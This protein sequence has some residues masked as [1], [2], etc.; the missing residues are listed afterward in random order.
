MKYLSA[1]CFLVVLITNFRGYANQFEIGNGDVSALK[2]AIIASNSNN[3]PDTIHLAFQG[4]YSFTVSDNDFVNGGANALPV[5]TKDGSDANYLTIFANGATLARSGTIDVLRLLYLLDCKV[6]IHDMNLIG[7]STQQFANKGGA[8]FLNS[9][10]LTIY[11]SLFKDNRAAEGG[12]IYSPSSDGSLVAKNCT[13]TG[14]TATFGTGAAIAK[15]YGPMSLEN[16]TVV[17]NRCVNVNTP[18]AI[19]NM[20]PLNA[21][22][23]T[24]NIYL[25]NTIVARNTYD[26]PGSPYNGQEFDI[27]GAVYTQGNN[28]IGA[29]PVVTQLS[30]PT[31]RQGEPNATNDYVGVQGSP[32]NPMLDQ[33]GANGYFTQSFKPLSGS[34]ALINNAGTKSTSTPL[35]TSNGIIPHEAYSGDVITVTGMNMAG[36]TKVQFTGSQSYPVTT[37]ATNAITVAVPSNAQTGK[38]LIMDNVPNFLF[39]MLAIKVKP[40]V[41]PITP[42][43]VATAKSASSIII[44]WND[45]Q[46]EESYRIEYKT[47]GQSVYRLLTIVNADAT[48]YT[49]STF[50]CNTEYHFRIIAVGHGVESSPSAI[51]I[52]TTSMDLPNAPQ[53]IVGNQSPNTGEH[54]V[55]YKT[56]AE[57]GLIYSWTYN[58]DGA[59]L[60]PNAASVS[61]DFSETATPGTLSVTSSN[62]CGN[63]SAT[64]L[65]INPGTITAMEEPAYNLIRIYPNPSN[66]QFIIDG[67][68][69]RGYYTYAIRDIT[70]QV[71]K[72]GEAKG[73]KLISLSYASA[74]VYSVIVFIN[75]EQITT[76]LIIVD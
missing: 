76:K 75:N 7:G 21:N 27:A 6:V 59:T 48:S 3:Q 68:E 43:L 35:L 49:A 63:S 62:S 23:A 4:M 12:A 47:S 37:A 32:I 44:T 69:D 73:K 54:D 56:A 20:I 55:L 46:H 52:A 30:Q 36:I 57:P 41:T 1:C 50:I 72:A 64:T 51:A 29:Y 28:F 70:G 39:S 25:K 74:G 10:R 11:N 31:F 18:A 60:Y 13:F 33:L 53:A 38:L 14:N 17:D 71:I 58:G 45:V 15:M 61:I 67:A 16:C 22:T 34:K 65:L 19:F 40:I 9:G 8:I 2:A 5:I 26:N 24:D 66:R 42:N